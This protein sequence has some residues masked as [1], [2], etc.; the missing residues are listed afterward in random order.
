MV[1]ANTELLVYNEQSS[2]IN[3]SDWMKLSQFVAMKDYNPACLFVD[4]TDIHNNYAVHYNKYYYRVMYNKVHALK[5]C[6]LYI[7]CMV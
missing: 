3:S 5:S 1:L 2:N 6:I 4:V 7:I